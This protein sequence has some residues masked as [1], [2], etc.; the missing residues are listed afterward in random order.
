MKV[1]IADDD[2]IFSKMLGTMLTRWGYEPVYARDGYE[3]LETL[4]SQMPP[5]IAI[6]DYKLPGLNGV[7]VCREL[8]LDSSNNVYVILMIS[9]DGLDDVLQGLDAGADDYVTKPVDPG[10]IKA[11]VQAGRK[12]AELYGALLYTREVVMEQATL[13]PLTG[14]PNRNL[15][16]A[17]LEQ[18]ILDAVNRTGM[19]AVAYLDLDNFKVINDTLG[20]VYGDILLK[21]VAQRLKKLLEIQ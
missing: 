14:L 11:R 9:R 6:L 10:E 2:P 16:N 17:K 3:A 1:L 7:S 21:A 20:H 13:D 19:L 18:A 12:I 5:R 4:Q 8:R 15:C